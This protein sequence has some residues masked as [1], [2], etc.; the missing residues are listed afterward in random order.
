MD[1]DV[2]LSA[3][4]TWFREYGAELV[5][6]IDETTRQLIREL[7][8]AGV[9]E[10]ENP[11]EIAARLRRE[12]EAVSAVRAERIARTEALRAAN[13]GAGAGYDYAREALGLEL[14]KVW[15]ATSD[16]RTRADHVEADG[17]RVP[18]D[19]PFTVGGYETPHPLGPGLPASQTVNC[20]C[21]WAVE[22]V[23]RPAKTWRE[24]RN[25]RIRADYPALRDAEGQVSALATLAEREHVSVRTV[26]RALGWG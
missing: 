16:S 17:Q 8:A 21:T 10:G 13:T 9:A 2:F 4:L 7:V 15:I 14:E 11:R 25:D 23:D 1:P 6:L 20:R 5:G 26:E 24:E 12:W 18:Y 3:A 22:V 19:D